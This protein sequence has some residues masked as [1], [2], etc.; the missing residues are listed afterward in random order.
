VGP[1]RPLN[2][3]SLMPPT[4]LT[5]VLAALLRTLRWLGW[6]RALV[7]LSFGEVNSYAAGIAYMLQ[8]RAWTVL[9]RQPGWATVH[10][11]W[12]TSVG[13]A[14]LRDSL[15]G[16][17]DP[18]DQLELIARGGAGFERRERLYA[19]AAQTIDIASYYLQADDTGRATVH[20]LTACVQRGVRVRLLV[21]RFMTFKK[22]QEVSELPALLS[23]AQAAG[24]ELRQWHDPQW[25]YASNHRKM[26]VVDGLHDGRVAIVGGRNFADHYRG[27]AWRDVDLVLQG[28]SVAPLA[29]LFDAVWVDAAP[30]AVA[31]AHPQPPWLDH[32]PAGILGDPVLRFVLAAIGSARERVEI[33]LAYFVAHDPL[34]DALVGAARRGVRVRLLTNSAESTDLPFA[35]WTTGEGLRRLLEGGCQVH[36]RRGSGRT[37]HCK[38]AVIDGRWVSFGSHNLDYFSPRLCCETNL[39]VHDERLGALLQAFFETGWAEADTATPDA[40]DAWLRGAGAQRWFDRLFRDFQ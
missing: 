9:H 40:V 20:A 33:E 18:T 28:P 11:A 24:I 6:P 1:Y 15:A 2:D 30:G 17:L 23:Q 14:G 36:L 4:V 16:R 3:W 25:P 26:I 39:V 35:T 37:L 10:R 19:A 12:A 5:A 13:D 27:D 7:R 34:C 32:A 29:A 21:D 31:R 22:T 38:Y 8:A